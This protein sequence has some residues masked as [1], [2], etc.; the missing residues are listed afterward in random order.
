MV[1][2]GLTRELAFSGETGRKEK[3]ME[4]DF[5]KDMIELDAAIKSNAERDNTFTLSVLQRAKQ[6]II[7]QKEKLEA[8]EDTGLTPKEIMDGKMLTGW[9]PVEERLPEGGE[10]VL[11]CTGNGWILVAWYGINRQ[12]WHITPTGITHDDIIAWMPMPEPYKPETLREAGKEAGAY[13]DAPT[14]QSAT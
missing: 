13:A 1:F 3:Q 7:Q 14:L 6:L 10:D 8:Y 9:I 4:R 11:V 2:A 12:S 5:E